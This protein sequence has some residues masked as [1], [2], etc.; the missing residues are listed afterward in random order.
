MSY[1]KLP[2][3][4]LIKIILSK[5]IT[6]KKW[7]TVSSK[8]QSDIVKIRKEHGIQK[9]GFTDTPSL[10]IVYFDHHGRPNCSEH[11]AMNCYEHQ[12]YR[13][14]MCGVAVNLEDVAILK[15]NELKY[16]VIVR[17]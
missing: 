1:D 6:I 11:G 8:F 15:F 7:K 12:I 16:T 17:S 3:E 4:T 13:C 14:V 10:N 5:D 9:D 2:P